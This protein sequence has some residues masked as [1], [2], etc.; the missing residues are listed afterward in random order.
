VAPIVFE[1]VI[2]KSL[3]VRTV[4]NDLHPTIQASKFLHLG[5]DKECV[6]KYNCSHPRHS[7]T[8]RYEINGLTPPDVGAAEP[9]SAIDNP[10]QRINRLAIAHY[11]HR[12]MR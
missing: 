10:T 11:R 4:A 5:D 9:N 2:F 12:D 6:Q 8:P 1:S 3:S 7:R